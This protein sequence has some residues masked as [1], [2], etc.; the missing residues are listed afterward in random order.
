MSHKLASR[1]TKLHDLG[2]DRMG[3]EVDA[4]RDPRILRLENLDTD[5]RPPIGALA[6]TTQAV[7]EDAANSYLPFQGGAALRQAATSRV[8]RQSGQSYDPQESCLITAGG[9]S[10]I[11]DV[12]LTVIEPGEKVLLTDPIYIGLLNRVSLAGGVAQ[13]ISYRPHQSGWRLD[14]DELRSSNSRD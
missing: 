2:V 9:L 13:F 10:G 5:L 12:L 14:L 3:G 1:V 4:A 11:L 7:E 8:S 6:A